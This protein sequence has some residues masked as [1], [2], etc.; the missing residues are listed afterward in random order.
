MKKI[1]LLSI[2]II[3]VNVVIAQSKKEQ[4]QSL[5]FRV[6]SI[7]TILS[8][9]RNFFTQKEQGYTVKGCFFTTV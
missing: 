6:D 3:S 7:N 4:I 9:E 8:S 1:V 5:T 2:Y